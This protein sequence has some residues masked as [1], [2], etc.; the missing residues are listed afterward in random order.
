ML[1]QNIIGICVVLIVWIKTFR[2]I[3]Y[4][5]DHENGGGHCLCTY[6]MYPCMLYFQKYKAN[7]PH[8]GRLMV[9]RPKQLDKRVPADLVSIISKSRAELND[10]VLY[11]VQRDVVIVKSVTLDCTLNALTLFMLSSTLIAV[12]CIILTFINI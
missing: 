7:R 4:L 6:R 11:V 10:V 1:C 9:G 5:Y 3:A 2:H 8:V 12:L